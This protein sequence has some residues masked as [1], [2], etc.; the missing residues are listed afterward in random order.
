MPN[1][2][3]FL[4]AVLSVTFLGSGAVMARAQMRYLARF[5]DVHGRDP[6]QGDRFAEKPWLFFGAIPTVMRDTFRAYDTAQPDPELER[7]RAE[8]RRSKLVTF[9]AFGLLFALA[10]VRLVGIA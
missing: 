4:A 1:T 9:S 5:R 7:R 3:D 8:M 2:L 10:I 6:L